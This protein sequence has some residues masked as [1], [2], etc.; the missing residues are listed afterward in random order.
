MS[1]HVHPFTFHYFHFHLRTETDSLY[2][3]L[4]TSGSFSNTATNGE[5]D[6]VECQQKK[7][8]LRHVCFHGVF[9]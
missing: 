2:S 7:G 9:V 4:E 3:V 1:Q 5:E 6:Y 8:R